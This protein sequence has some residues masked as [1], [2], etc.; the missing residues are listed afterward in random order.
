V[1]AGTVQALQHHVAR[2]DDLAR[3]AWADLCEEDGDEAVAR[4]LRSLPGLAEEMESERRR[5]AGA[6][7][8][9]TPLNL[10]LSLAGEWT[11]EGP[12]A[13]APLRWS[14]DLRTLLSRGEE[15]TAALEWLAHRLGLGAVTDEAT[16]RTSPGSRN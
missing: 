4:A 8:G 3:L 13:G 6:L 1:F 9:R 12:A 15:V 2:G 5:W 11:W 16:R 10:V 14:A 7:P